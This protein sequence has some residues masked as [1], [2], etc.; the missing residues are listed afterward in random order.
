MQLKIGLS[1]H[2][3]STGQNDVDLLHWMHRTALELIGQ[4]GLGHSFDALDQD[5]PY[6]KVTKAIKELSYVNLDQ[7]L[8]RY[9]P[10]LFFFGHRAL[11][12][13]STLERMASP[14]LVKLGPAWLRRWLLE[15]LPNRRIQRLKDISDILDES[16]RK[17]FFGK[18]AALEA[19]DE[20]VKEQIASG[21]DIISILRK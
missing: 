13:N 21:K 1:N 10:I 18:K 16:T 2:I 6:N 17:V 19:G 3:K 12:F 20:L 7:I 11:L 15:Q 9:L 8:F 5:V 14:Y 4:G